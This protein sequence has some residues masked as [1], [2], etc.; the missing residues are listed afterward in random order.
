MCL[1]M[2][3]AKKNITQKIKKWKKSR[4]NTKKKKPTTNTL[5]YKCTVTLSKRYQFQTKKF[6]FDAKISVLH[7]QVVNYE[8]LLKPML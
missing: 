5:L 3:F 4:K 7:V 1:F 2:F 6:V 8:P